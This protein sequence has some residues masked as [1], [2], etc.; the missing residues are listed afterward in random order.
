MPTRHPRK[1]ITITP[2]RAALLDEVAALEGK[3]P[4][5]GGLVEDGARA[6]IE[7]LRHASS[8]AQAARRRVADRVRSRSLGQDPEAA[9][10]VKHLGLGA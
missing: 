8:S 3:Q 5:L 10:R 2:S 1:M 7:R 6:R 4:D 9:D